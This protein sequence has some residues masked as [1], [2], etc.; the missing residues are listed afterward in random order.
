MDDTKPRQRARRIAV[1][2][3][4]YGAILAAGHWGGSWLVSLVG[5]DLGADTTSPAKHAVA[6][7]LIVYAMLM[8]IPFLPGMEV[9]LALLAAFG[10]NVA[11]FVY[12][13][14]VVALSTS[15]LIGRLVPV[16]LIVAFFGF[17]RLRGAQE[18]VRGV[19]PLSAEERLELLM[20]H[21]PQRI[22]PA[23]LKYRYLAIAVAFNVPG[24]AVIGGGGGIALLAGMSGLFGFAMFLAVL[25][26]AVA[27]IPLA[28]MFLS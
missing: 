14:T 5:D 1:A 7:G 2:V 24:N 23:L 4:M 6:A 28:V 12:L 13:A 11:P 8:A 15:F 25:A 27:P 17:L 18:Y 20:A 3:L 10:K 16:G 22:V 9:S 21:A 19:A 26:I